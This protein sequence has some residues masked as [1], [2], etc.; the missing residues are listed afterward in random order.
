M[1]TPE[2]I[3]AMKGKEKITMLTCYDYSFASLMDG[4]VDILL[5]GDSLGNVI[6]GYDTTQKVTMEDMLR[7]TAAVS[8]GAKNTL[9]VGDLPYQSYETKEDAAKNG[10]LLL[11]AGA[12]AVKPENKPEIAAALVMEGIPVMGHIGLLPQTAEKYTVQGR[13]E[14]AAQQLIKDAKALENAG[15][16]SLVIESVPSALARE[17]TEM[18]SIPTIGI[19]AGPSCDGQVVVSYDLLGIFNKF[20]PKFVKRYAQLD[21]AVKEAVAQYAKEVKSGAFP[22]KEFSF[23]K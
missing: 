10:R 6:L 21:K 11:K 15:A 14:K 19:G 23:E 16:F 9:I 20:R 4:M 3:V 18:V 2:D 1:K 7:H 22:T 13:D 17:I 12:H 8:R 5:V